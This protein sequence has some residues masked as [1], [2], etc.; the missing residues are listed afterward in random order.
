M[1][2]VDGFIEILKEEVRMMESKNVISHNG[3]S[4]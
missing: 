3:L 4:F 1:R 2:N